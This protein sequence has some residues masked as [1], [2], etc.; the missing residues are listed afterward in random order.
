WSVMLLNH[1]C[2]TFDHHH[3]EYLCTPRPRVEANG[4]DLGFIRLSDHS[5]D[6]LGSM[7]TFV[8]LRYH[9]EKWQERRLTRDDGV[10]V[11]VGFPEVLGARSLDEKN[12]TLTTSVFCLSAVGGVDPVRRRGD[13]DYYDGSVRYDKRY[14]VPNSFTGMSGGGLWRIRIAFRE[15]LQRYEIFERIFSGVVFYQVASRGVV[16]DIRSHGPKSIYEYAIDEFILKNPAPKG[17]PRRKKKPRRR[18]AP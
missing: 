16:S 6:V 2:L 18:G 11:E 3:V 13:F 9:R 15:R 10:W 4:P 7:F 14:S 1:Q 12:R 5:A 8:N 17:R